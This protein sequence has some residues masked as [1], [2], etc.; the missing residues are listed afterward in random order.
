MN[1]SRRNLVMGALAISAAAGASSGARAQSGSEILVAYLTRSGNTRVIA[2]Q[3]RRDLG[4]DLFEIRASQPYPA[5]YEEMVAQAERER[6]E[7]YE[8]PLAELVDDIAVYRTVFLGFPIW[9]M[10]APS[11]IRSFLSKHDLTRKRIIPFITH[12]GYG[13][14][15]SLDVVTA[16]A[17][18]AEVLEG[19]SLECDQERRTME[20]VRAWLADVQDV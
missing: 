8:P 4:A 19:F 1:L 15:N 6:V 17:P 5:D 11:V 7:G 14:G 13:V 16:H 12:G 2:G 20:T 9:G 18:Q 10:T 3:I